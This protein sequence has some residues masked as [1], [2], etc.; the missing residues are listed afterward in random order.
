VNP[1]YSTRRRPAPVKI[2]RAQAGELSKQLAGDNTFPRGATTFATRRGISASVGPVL[3]ISPL[4]WVNDSVG[5]KGLKPTSRARR[6]K[7]YPPIVRGE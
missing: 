1:R 7:G 2:W 4:A 5:I 6:K 3:R